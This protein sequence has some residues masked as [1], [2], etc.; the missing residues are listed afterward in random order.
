V[1]GYGNTLRGDDAF[2]PVVADRLR[3]VADYE[4]VF[5]LT[6]HQ[7]TPELASDIAACEHVVFIDAAITSPAGELVCRDLTAGEAD[8]GPLVHSL[9]PEQLL[10]LARLVYGRAPSASLV[11]VGGLHFDL[12]DQQL[13]PPVAAAI[14]PAVERIRDLIDRHFARG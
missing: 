3:N 7:L 12:G 1:I 6:C 10:T 11:C 13:S 14:E 9:G 5:V 4:R 8:S 2:G